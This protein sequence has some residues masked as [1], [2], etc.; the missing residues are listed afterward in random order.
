VTPLLPPK[1]SVCK[2]IGL[3]SELGNLNNVYCYQTSLCSGTIY[4]DAIAPEICSSGSGS[5]PF[6]VYLGHTGLERGNY[7]DQRLGP[8]ERE[9]SDCNENLRQELPL[10]EVLGELGITIGT[11]L[12]GRSTEDG[13]GGEPWD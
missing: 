3:L 5:P 8:V 6:P 2:L 13:E 4:Y 11:K 7:W 12:F 1:V 9:L 10:R